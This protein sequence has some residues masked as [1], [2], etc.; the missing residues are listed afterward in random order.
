[1]MKANNVLPFAVEDKILGGSASI[2][3]FLN[4]HKVLTDERN[5]ERL[6]CSSKT[7]SCRKPVQKSKEKVKQSHDEQHVKL[8]HFYF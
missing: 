4:L 6:A 5:K 3:F 1:M 2:L 7:N 8:I